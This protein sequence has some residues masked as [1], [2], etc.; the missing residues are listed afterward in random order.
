VRP[1]HQAKE[2]LAN[3]AAI[4]HT[5]PRVKKPC[6]ISVFFICLLLCQTGVGQEIKI[7]INHLGY[8]LDAPKRAVVLGHAGDDVT[9]FKIINAQSGKEMLSGSAKKIGAV[10]K[11]KDWIFWTAD[12]GALNADGNY[13]LEC[14]TS[15]GAVRSFPFKIERNLLE[16]NTLLDVVAWFKWQRCSGLLDQ[17]DRH[18]QFDGSTNTA[19]VH[20][21]WF[22]AT[23]D[24]GKHLSHLSFSTYFNPQQIP[25]T[26]WSLLKSYEELNRRGDGNFRQYKRRLLDEAMFG[27]DYL[28]R[29]KSPGG[30]FY[31]SISA[32]GPE[33]AAADRRIAKEG[34]GFAIKT[35]KNAAFMGETH[36]AGENTAYEV[37]YRNGGGLAIAALALASLQPSSGEFSHSE[38]LKTAR[39]AFL[40]LEKNNTLYLNDGKENIVD[41]YCAL[42]AAT[43]LYKAEKNIFYKSAAEKRAQNLMN[44]L[45]TSAGHTNYWRA[46]DGDR[47]FFHAAD[48]G[49]P[50]VSLLEYCE[51][52]DA[53]MQKR[54]LETVRKSLEFEMQTTDEV[55][56]PFG[57]ARQ[58]VQ[59][60]N[61][62]RRTT[63]FFPHDTETSP[64]WQGENARLGSMA[65]AARMA[66]NYFKDDPVFTKRLQT[67]AWNQLNWILGLNPYD[68]CMLQGTGHNNPFYMFFDSYEYHNAPGGIVN[69]ITSGYR[70]PHDIDFN[71]SYSETGTDDS[72]RWGEQ[73]LPHDSWYLLAI[74]IK[75]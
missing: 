48:A 3:R 10:D 75:N 56:N 38:Y 28:V 65:T 37:G 41:D 59:S 13:W 15:K 2:T 64:W 11:W 49:M 20:G 12:F 72:W 35:N 60:T 45:I 31:R 17:A 22:D 9:T 62:F 54:I 34:S 27:A 24:Y 73:W 71:L 61:G 36:T 26:D 47:P 46:D 6:S 50:V 30:S 55:A 40:F 70:D 58:L 29:V 39:D 44:R 5:I 53:P 52:A 18:L 68:S 4:R 16:K 33:K 67:Y 66:A 74:S 23:G 32:P 14:A 25:A 7:L 57:Y 1:R 51:I 69:G 21:G 42:L 63:F 8:E 19:D 43:E